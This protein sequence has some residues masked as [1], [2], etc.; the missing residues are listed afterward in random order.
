MASGTDN[1]IKGLPPRALMASERA[2]RLVRQLLTFS[3]KQVRQLRT[4][5]LRHTVGALCE[6]LPRLLGEQ[7]R[8]NVVAV[9]TASLVDADPGMM[10]QM[11]MNLAVN[12][13]DAMPQGGTLTIAVETVAI[14]PDG[15]KQNREAR[16]GDFVCI[17]VGDT[18]CGMSAAVLQRIFEPFYTTKPVGKGTGLGLATVYGIAKQH[19]GWVEVQSQLGS[20][21]TFK[22]FIPVS[23]KGQVVPPAPVSKE[24][25]GGGTEGVLV[26]EDEAEVREF[27]VGLLKSKGYR[28]YEA[29]SGQQALEQWSQHREEIDLLLTDMVMPGGLMGRA[30]AERLSA[31]NPELRVIYTSGYSPGLAAKDSAL[32]EGRNF[33]PKPYAPATLLKMV[34]DTLDSPRTPILSA[35]QN[36]AL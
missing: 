17:S 28:V 21:S 26:A 25:V 33:L 5:D 14:T 3:R 24:L 34:R 11:L 29:A 15:T 22:I 13:R 4:M 19:D 9:E 31:Q 10:E 20:G 27:V 32:I 23:A 36:W 16:A 7:I 8:V 12:A 6:M 30:L 1:S 18:G 35:Y 2:S